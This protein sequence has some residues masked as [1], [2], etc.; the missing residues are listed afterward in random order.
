[1]REN[2]YEWYFSYRHIIYLQYFTQFSYLTFSYPFL[3]VLLICVRNPLFRTFSLSL[4]DSY[5]LYLNRPITFQLSHSKPLTIR[6][7]YTINRKSINI[8]TN[9]LHTQ[10]CFYWNSLTQRSNITMLHWWI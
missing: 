5:L 1:M 8:T 2:M 4:R 7:A 9:R 6:S 3:F 10:P